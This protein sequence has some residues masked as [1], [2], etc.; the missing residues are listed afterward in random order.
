MTGL[1]LGVLA[2][3]LVHAIAL[4]RASGPETEADAETHLHRGMPA[5]LMP[6]ALFLAVHALESARLSAW[7]HSPAVL[8]SA[9]A[10]LMLVMLNQLRRKHLELH[11]GGAAFRIFYVA[12]GALQTV[13][14][15]LAGYYAWEEGILG[16]GLFHPQWVILGLA[17]GHLI[18]GISLLFSHRSL[19]SLRDIGVYIADPRPVSAYA[20]RSPRQVFAC[21]DVSLIEELV[22]RVAAQGLLLAWTGNAWAAILVTAVVFSVVHRHFFY[23]H[24]VDSAEFLAFSILLGALYHLTGSLTLVVLVHA[25]RNLEIVYFD[26]SK[27]P[28]D[29]A[30]S[31]E[32]APRAAIGARWRAPVYSP[33]HGK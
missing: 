26:Q 18:F 24:V 27:D 30:G 28:A 10:L 16:R 9:G 21:I 13:L 7:L 4:H 1:F 15:V 22:Y 32:P 5:P 25:V 19:E 29:G 31:A 33:M 6:F 2:A 11:G 23:N 20:A 12:G 3:Y 17:G 8:A 14:L